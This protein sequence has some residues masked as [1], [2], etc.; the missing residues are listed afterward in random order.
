MRNVS[1]TIC[2]ENQNTYF[3]F[4]KFFFSKIMQFMR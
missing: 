1:D 4:G 3:M 2:K